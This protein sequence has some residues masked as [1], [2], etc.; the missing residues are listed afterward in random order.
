LSE[1]ESLIYNLLNSKPLCADELIEASG[2]SSA[3][4]M[5]ILLKLEMH[6]SIKQ[7][8]GKMYIK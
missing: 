7:L 8:P 6:K 3:K 1:E 5:A 4:V 2:L